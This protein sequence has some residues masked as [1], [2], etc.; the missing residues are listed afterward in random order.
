[1]LNFDLPAT[2]VLTV[3]LP[4]AGEGIAPVAVDAHHAESSAAPDW[5]TA[6]TL[7]GLKAPA[8]APGDGPHP[9]PP[10]RFAADWQTALSLSGLKAPAVAPGDGPNPDPPPR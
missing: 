2:G 8:E 4:P 10:P 5:Q 6:L 3:A 7:S 1:M 9:D